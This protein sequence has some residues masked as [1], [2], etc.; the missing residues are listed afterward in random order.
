[1][2]I[3]V[4]SVLLAIILPTIKTVREAAL[5]KQAKVGATALAQAAIRYKTEYGFWPGQLVPHDSDRFAAKINPDLPQQAWH[6]AIISRGGDTSVDLDFKTDDSSI[7]LGYVDGATAFNAVYQAFARVWQDTPSST[8]ELNPLNPRGI[9]F[10]NLHNEHDIHT[11]AYPDPW[12][13]PYVLLMGLNPLTQFR[14]SYTIA[15]ANGT[16]TYENVI[17][18][19]ICFAYSRGS[20][21][22]TNLIYSAGVQ[23]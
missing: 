23:P 9:A 3:S 14:Y 21:T 2:V 18:N 19:T 4:L 17:S 11:V 20:A 5:R 15:S 7:E 6:P 13:R 16:I 12:G 22:D 10:L 1:M 8:P